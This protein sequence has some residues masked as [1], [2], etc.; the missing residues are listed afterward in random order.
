[1]EMRV[2]T[3]RILRGIGG[4]YL[5]ED[6]DGALHHASARGL[7]RLTGETPTAGDIV[8]CDLSGDQDRPWQIVSI[9]Q[10]KNCLIRPSVA[11][12]DGLLITI[13]ADDPPPDY[14]M[15]DKLI[16]ICRVHRIEPV[17]VLTKTDLTDG[18]ELLLEPYRPAK[19]RLIETSPEDTLGIQALARWLKG[20]TACLAG[21]SGVGKS[22]LLNRL[23]NDSVMP[24][25][26][27]SK[28]IGRGRHTTREVVFFPCCGGYLAD[29][30]G[31]STL[32]LEDVGIRPDD[33]VLGYPEMDNLTGQCRF[34]NCRHIG[35]PGCAV[36]RIEIHADRLKRYR[37]FRK[38]MEEYEQWQEPRS[39][40]V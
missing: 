18:T 21:L 10:R 4:L 9:H 17:L 40:R 19:L 28:R 15:V 2:L 13:S 7:F 36:D 31:F 24:V 8:D 22:T 16:I 6:S 34:N 27:V 32:S 12:L 23:M 30:P 14:L 37:A 3:G 33:I 1:M 11:N 38:Q 20:K 25:S 5:I 26:A 29:T 39:S 35:E